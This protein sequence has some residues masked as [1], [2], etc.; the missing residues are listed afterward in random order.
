MSGQLRDLVHL[1]GD[2]TT[3]GEVLSQTLEPQLKF[4]CL[5]VCLLNLNSFAVGR[6]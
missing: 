6:V 2:E 1:N 5:Y 4:G 3:F